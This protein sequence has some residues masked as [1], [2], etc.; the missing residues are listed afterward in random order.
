[1]S[2]CS[3]FFRSVSNHEETFR[4]PQPKTRTALWSK[5]KASF[6]RQRSG[7]LKGFIIGNDG[8]PVASLV[9]FL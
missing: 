7:L 1:M 2:S 6:R 9:T 5:L 4:T 8:G 3:A